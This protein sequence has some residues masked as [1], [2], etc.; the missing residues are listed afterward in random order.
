MSK[1]VI[2]CP[3]CHNYTT[4][5][6]VFNRHVKCTC[7]YE[8]SVSRDKIAAKECAHCHNTVLFDQSKGEKAICPGKNGGKPL[9]SRQ[10]CTVLLLLGRRA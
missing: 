5:S 9:G 3:Q 4:A 6:K 2:E 8:I 10:G 1:F 7:G